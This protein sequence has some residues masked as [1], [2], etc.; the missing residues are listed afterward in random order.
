MSWRHL[1]DD[2]IKRY[3]VPE[4]NSSDSDLAFHY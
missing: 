4:V 2:P 1:F 3:F